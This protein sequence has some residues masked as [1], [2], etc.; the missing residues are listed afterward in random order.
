[1]TE[2]YGADVAQVFAWLKAHP[3]A[4]QAGKE[5]PIVYSRRLLAES[6]TAYHAGNRDEAQRL[7]LASYLEGFE[8][9]EASLNAIDRNLRQEVETQ[10]IAYRDLIRRG[11]PAIKSRNSP[12]ASTDCS[13][14]APRGS[15]AKRCRRP[16]PR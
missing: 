7:A 6:A 8:L 1:M 3:S 16:P 13:A 15:A 4:L 5:S 9:A 2:K 12:L 11:A 14:P 10:M